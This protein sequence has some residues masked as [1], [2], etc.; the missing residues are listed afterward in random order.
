[1]TNSFSRSITEWFEVDF[2]LIFLFQ[3]ED[4]GICFMLNGIDPKVLESL[5]QNETIAYADVFYFTGKSQHSMTTLAGID[6]K[7]WE[8]RVDQIWLKPPG[9]LP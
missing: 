1:M 3:K 2:R 8:N 7:A 9:V 5:L 4:F 6:F